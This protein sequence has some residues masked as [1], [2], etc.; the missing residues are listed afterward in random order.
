MGKNLKL[1]LSLMLGIPAVMI[2]ASVAIAP[3][4]KITASIIALLVGLVLGFLML[5]LVEETKRDETAQAAA[6]T[7]QADIE[8]K[9]DRKTA[10]TV[11]IAL[12][13]MRKLDEYYALNKSQAKRSFTASIIAVAVGFATIILSVLYVKDMSTKFVGGLAGVLGQFIGASFFYLHNKSLNQLNLFYGK[14]ISLQNTM[15]ALQV[16]EKLTSHK[17]DTMKQIALE[18]MHRADIAAVGVETNGAKTAKHPTPRA[19]QKPAASK[20]APPVVPG[21]GAA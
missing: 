5:V 6:R 15:L 7:A 16:C 18:L 11:D 3:N 10:D 9:I 1:T 8:G 2:A 20:P 13:N 4:N 12:L 17:E 19:T 21:I 14:L